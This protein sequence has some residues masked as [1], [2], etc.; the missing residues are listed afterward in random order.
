VGKKQNFCAIREN[1]QNNFLTSNSVCMTYTMPVQ[2][3]T[4]KILIAK[5]KM[6]KI[7]TIYQVPHA[8]TIL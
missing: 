4:V 7:W 1:E 2:E 5:V 3:K 6:Q 8:N